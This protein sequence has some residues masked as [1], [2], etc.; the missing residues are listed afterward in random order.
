MTKRTYSSGDRPKSPIIR[1]LVYLISDI[2]EEPPHEDHIN[3]G[4]EPVL[5]WSY[6][7]D[8]VLELSEYLERVTAEKEERDAATDEAIFELDALVCE[9]ADRLDKLE[10][11]GA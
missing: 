6:V 4:Q 7:V 9:N 8:E 2:R 3:E 11:G 10:A 5:Q 1:D